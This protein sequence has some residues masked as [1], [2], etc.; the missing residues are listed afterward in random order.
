MCLCS[1]LLCASSPPPPA[2]LLERVSSGNAT[3]AVHALKLDWGAPARM[4]YD[5]VG[6]RP[7][8]H[9]RRFLER[10][11]AAA[12]GR[13]PAACRLPPPAGAPTALRLCVSL[14]ATTQDATTDRSFHLTVAPTGLGLECVSVHGCVA[15]LAELA[16]AAG[17]G[18]A[19]GGAPL[20][21]SA[22]YAL[23]VVTLGT[24]PAAGLDAL[25]A[26][27][28]AQGS[29]LV[30]Q[31]MH[32]PKPVG[33]L[34]GLFGLKLYYAAALYRRLAAQHPA[35]LVMFVDA[36]DVLLLGPPGDVAAGYQRAVAAAADKPWPPGAQT[37]VLFSAERYI[38]PDRFKADL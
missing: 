25:R 12:R 20:V 22:H 38:W 32:D 9:S 28:A 14:F 24:K 2:P 3:V 10:A 5:C 34:T 13:L 6:N 11:A 33:H 27:V 37:P 4:V 17:E 15:G 21:L 36:Y 18:C 16:A 35:D 1:L 23:R 7:L 31:G 26:S 19:V 30:V 29:V 8:T